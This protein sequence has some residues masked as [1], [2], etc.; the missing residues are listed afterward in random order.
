MAKT[1]TEN[2]KHE[3]RT[4]NV[5]NISTREVEGGTRK[6]EGYASVFNSPTVIGD[7]WFKEII[8]PGAFARSIS[9]KD[10]RALFNHNWDNVLGRIKSGTL[11]LEED[12]RGLKFIIDLPATTIANDLTESIDRGDIDQCS[13]GFIPVVERWDHDTVPATRQIEEVELFEISVVSLPA[14]DETTVSLRSQETYKL[15][16]HRRALL[17]QIKNSLGE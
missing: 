15:I 13:F 10:V 7:E 9:E 14:Y 11:Q 16:E 6:L 3:V 2:P 4:F 8:M 17:S 5:S 12:E 1:K